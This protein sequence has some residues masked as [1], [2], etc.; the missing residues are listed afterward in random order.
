MRQFWDS[1]DEVIVPKNIP[2]AG[3]FQ[4][5]LV[6]I[7]T[8]FFFNANNDQTGAQLVRTM[9]RESS[10]QNKSWE[11]RD[12]WYKFLEQMEHESRSTKDIVNDNS[13][14]KAH[15]FKTRVEKA[16]LI[17]YMGFRLA[18]V[19]ALKNY[20]IN[21]TEP[22]FDYVDDEI[23]SMCVGTEKY[24]RDH[25][26]TGIYASIHSPFFAE[27]NEQPIAK[28]K[29]EHMWTL[30]TEY[31]K[32]MGKD[33]L[34]ERKERDRKDEDFRRWAQESRIQEKVR[35]EQEAAQEREAREQRKAQ[36]A[37]PFLVSLT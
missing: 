6:H 5:T 32:S 4:R 35:K 15:A 10:T 25:M 2:E 21:K 7:F 30:M 12:E 24:Y 16:Y 14:Q 20:P 37:N 31:L 18:K 23:S 19:W 1:L 33:L 9:H 27:T 17:T 11:L 26:R 3:T 29:L 34:A 28:H 8:D 13:V 22:V 36:S